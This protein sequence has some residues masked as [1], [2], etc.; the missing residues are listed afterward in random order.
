MLDLDLA[1]VAFQVINFLV[2]VALLG[3]FLFR[4]LRTK[5]NERGRI[6]SETIQRARDQEAEA[7]QLR[8]QWQERMRT[9]EQQAEE[10]I[11]AAQREAQAKSADLLREARVRLD[12]LTEEMRADLERYRN[13]VVVLHYDEILDTVMVLAGHVVQ[14]VTTRRTHDDLVTN[15]CASIYQLP[16][17]DV[18]EYRQIMAG[19]VPIAFVS[20]PV[21]LSPEQIRT[22]EDTLSSLVDQ[23]VALQ[24]TTDPSL[25]AGIQVR[26]GDKLIENSIR[27]QLVR[28]RGR[29]QRDLVARIEEI[30][31]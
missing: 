7:A 30:E 13:E 22:L 19:R 17:T 14:S 9:I 31:T 5:I 12:R 23:R 3:F 27:Q 24:M 2:L 16:Q 11:L 18:E 6:V 20:T 8:A 10:I 21:A 29:V 1:T 15:F 25:V 26:L 4:P 28:I